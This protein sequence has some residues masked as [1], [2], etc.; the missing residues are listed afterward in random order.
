MKRDTL[1]KDTPVSGCGKLWVILPV[2]FAVC[3]K[4]PRQVTGGKAYQTSPS[5]VMDLLLSRVWNKKYPRPLLPLVKPHNSAPG[6]I[7]GSFRSG[8][9]P[10]H[11]SWGQIWLTLTGIKHLGSW[12]LHRCLRLASDRHRLPSQSP[13]LRLSAPAKAAAEQAGSLPA[14]ASPKFRTGLGFLVIHLFVN[15]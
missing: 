5:Q 2:A 9:F 12:L 11:M 6:Y 14:G 7:E 1:K 8:V 10:K 15:F 3:H 13:A 4:S